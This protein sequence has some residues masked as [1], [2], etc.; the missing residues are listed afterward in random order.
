[1]WS[2]QRGVFVNSRLV[3]GEIERADSHGL[4]SGRYR[5]LVAEVHRARTSAGA[6]PQ[7]AAFARLDV[8]VTAAAFTYAY[9]LAHGRSDPSRF[10][11]VY[12]RRARAFDVGA[13]LDSIATSGAIDTLTAR[14]APALEP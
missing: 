10:G 2:G 5:A 9:E 13:L 8:A 14:A 12:Y 7:D 3:L 6:D 1:M 11:S 4:D